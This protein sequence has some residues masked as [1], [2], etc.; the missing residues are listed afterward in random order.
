V[1]RFTY[2][3]F[4]VSSELIS[5]ANRGRVAQAAKFHRHC[6]CVRGRLETLR[7]ANGSRNGGSPVRD[8]SPRLWLSRF[9][10]EIIHYAMWLYFCLP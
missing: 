3:R 1:K 6:A 8:G 5:L 9:P 7:H 4:S 10:P 2:E